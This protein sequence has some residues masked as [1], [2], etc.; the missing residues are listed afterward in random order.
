MKCHFKVTIVS[1]I[2]FFPLEEKTLC[3]VW[4]RKQTKQGG[5]TVSSV[6]KNNNADVKTVVELQEVLAPP[7]SSSKKKNEQSQFARLPL[8]LSVHQVLPNKKT[9]EVGACEVNLADFCTR[10]TEPYNIKVKIEYTTK[11]SKAFDSLLEKNPSQIYIQI[12][13][14]PEGGVSPRSATAPTSAVASASASDPAT[15]KD[16]S[17]D[18]NPFATNASASEKIDSEP[19]E[20]GGGGGITS[21]GEQEPAFKGKEEGSSNPFASLSRRVG[22]GGP[23]SG[24]DVSTSADSLPSPSPR[25][26]H[27]E[28]ESSGPS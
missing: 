6:V 23:G 2:N 17:R 5:S 28:D 24:N 16:N 13:P 22:G 1:L 3:V 7:S 25:I 21:D 27:L 20:A 14:R 19:E 4:K 15:A 11:P 8:L 26:S 9:K 12:D 18:S 10:K